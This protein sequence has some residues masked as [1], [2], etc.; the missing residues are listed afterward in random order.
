MTQYRSFDSPAAATHPALGQL[1]NLIT[2]DEDARVCKDIPPE[3]CDDQPR[4][5]FAYLS[6]NTLNKVADELS[7]SKL[8]LPWMFGAL[9]APAALA[10]FLV[11]IRESGV[12]LPQMAVAAYV[13]RMP[14]RQ[15]VWL[16]GGLLT[17]LA[18]FGM[19]GS[20]MLLDG[21]AAGWSVIAMLIV[22]S[23]ARGLCSVSAKDVLGKTVS[24]SRRGRLMGWS[25]GVGGVLTL[26]LGIGLT[27][28]PLEQAGRE[29][30][31]LMLFGA[32]LLWLVALVLFA[33]IR[34]QPGATGGGGN[35]FQVAL[36]NLRLLRDD[37]PFRQFVFGRTSML[38]VALAPPFYVLLAHQSAAGDL[39]GLG[40]LVI[41]SG[42]AAAISSPVW[43]ALGDRSSKTVMALGAAGA[44]VLGIAVSA[45]AYTAQPWL[46]HGWV[47]A[48]IF[49]LLTIMHSGVRLGR[50]VYL[51]DMSTEQTRAA[52]VA[53]SNSVIGVMMLLGGLIGLL[54]DRFGVVAVIAL[55][56]VWSLLSSAGAL[57]LP[58]VSEG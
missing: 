46:A 4:N 52:Y 42:L 25:A 38:A 10:G 5:F 55:L 11:P 57:R 31:A 40:M 33:G 7:S 21:A 3:S 32:G 34:E 44:G 16:L 12:L 19:A 18:L 37:P 2:G 58:E 14:R 6:A 24:K 8:V 54:A 35:A 39:A 23:L 30:F 1:Y 9:G 27:G 36:D 22:F 48:V 29:I 13:R 41:A 45:A 20:A 43:G 28:I 51:V 26:A 15:P 50:K 49:M 47:H 53:V 56:G 17:A